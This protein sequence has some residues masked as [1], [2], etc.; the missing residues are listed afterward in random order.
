VKR[1]SFFAVSD[2]V[3][4]RVSKVQYSLTFLSITATFL[5]RDSLIWFLSRIRLSVD[6]LFIN[7]IIIWLRC[8][9]P[10]EQVCASLGTKRNENA[11]I[12][13]KN[14]AVTITQIKLI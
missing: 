14:I 6:K 11:V 10:I 8:T 1:G 12:F 9:V 3:K 13:H 4:Q 7:K 5:S 2:D